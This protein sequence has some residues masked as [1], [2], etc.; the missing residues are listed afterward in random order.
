MPSPTPTPTKTNAFLW[1]GFL[2]AVLTF[3]FYLPVLHDEFVAWDDQVFIFD[4]P[5]LKA[6]N[7]TF[8]HWM[9]TN[10]D[11]GNWV[12]LSW[13]SLALDYQ[14]GGWSPWIYHLDNLILHTLNTA[15]RY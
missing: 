11:T 9:W 2:P 5:Q 1:F 7:P 14:I 8:F 6:L 10:L 13:L 3:L 15:C 4:N 12:P